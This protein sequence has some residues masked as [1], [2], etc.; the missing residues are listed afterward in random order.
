MIQEQISTLGCVLHNL[1]LSDLVTLYNEVNNDQIYSIEE[2]NKYFKNWRPLD[3]ARA[4]NQEKFRINEPYFV[5]ETR[6]DIFSN[7][8]YTIFVSVR[9]DA[10]YIDTE[11]IAESIFDGRE[12]PNN[13]KALFDDEEIRENYEWD[14]I[15]YVARKSG[16]EKKQVDKWFETIVF[17]YSKDWF[18]LYCNFISTL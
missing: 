4:A 5:M 9:N 2:L 6:K 3:I 10:Y 15:D 14:F 8:E 17:D 1:K 11:Y 7:E 18:V 12:L 16:A 13:V